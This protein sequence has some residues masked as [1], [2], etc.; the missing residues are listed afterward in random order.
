M[1][2]AREDIIKFSTHIDNIASSK[3]TAM[4]NVASDTGTALFICYDFNEQNG[5]YKGSLIRMEG[6][7]T[8]ENLNFYSKKITLWL[9]DINNKIQ[10]K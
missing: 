3:I 7:Y 1:I 5:I 4:K 10:K 9:K 6:D 2:I 8:C